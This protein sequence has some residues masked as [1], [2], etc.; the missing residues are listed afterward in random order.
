MYIDFSEASC[1]TRN[2][3]VSVAQVYFI[4][5]LEY[6]KNIYIIDTRTILRMYPKQAIQRYWQVLPTNEFSNSNFTFVLKTYI[7]HV[8]FNWLL[9]CF[10]LFIS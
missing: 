2:F 4:Y 5:V 6:E 1:R 3:I 8:N 9:E 7:R 10:Y